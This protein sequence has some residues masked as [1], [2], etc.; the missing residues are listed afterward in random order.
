MKLPAIKD[1]ELVINGTIT[2][3]VDGV[4][5]EA[6]LM[7]LTDDREEAHAFDKKFWDKKN[8][9]K[10]CTCTCKCSLACSFKFK[11]SHHYDL[12]EFIGY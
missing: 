11:L 7:Y 3:N 1:K 9:N 5:H 4:L 10:V 2:C 12:H 8:A 6:N